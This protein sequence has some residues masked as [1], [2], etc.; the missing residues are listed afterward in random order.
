MKTYV[1]LWS[2]L[3]HFLEW[4]MFQ[5][6]VAENIKTHFMSNTFFKKNRTVNEIMWKNLVQPDKPHMTI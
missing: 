3:A 1:H 5:T 4:E 6:K 2:Y